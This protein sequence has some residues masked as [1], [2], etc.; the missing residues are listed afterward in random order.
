MRQWILVTL[1]LGAS[2]GA[3]AQ[4][5]GPANSSPL[6]GIDEIAVV[7][8]N[9]SIS[10]RQL[11]EEI[12]RERSLIPADIEL[13]PSVLEQQLTERVV[14]A[15]LIQQLK[16]RLN[17]SANDEEI[18]AAIA[19]VAQQNGVSPSELLK[20]VRR[21][22]GL[23]EQAYRAQIA[24]TIS[25]SK[26]KQGLVG[27][28]I[29]VTPT[30]IDAQIAQ[31]AR[32]SNVAIELQDLL[33]PRPSGNAEERGAAVQEQM[34]SLSQALK[35]AD[36]DLEQVAIAMPEARL[37]NLGT[38]SMAQI[39]PRF[40]QAIATQPIGEVLSEPVVD[41]DGMHFLK[42]LSRQSEGNVVIPEA[43]V[44]HILLR[45]EGEQDIAAQKVLIDELYQR[46]QQGADFSVLASQYSQD[47]ASAARG[48]KLGWMSA[49]Q[50][51]PA[52][53][54]AML[55][56]PLNTV[57]QPFLSPYGWHIVRV[58]DRREVD[59]ADDVLRARIRESLFNKYL[60]DAWQQ[61]LIQLRQQAY[62]EFR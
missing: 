48:G 28:D 55:N 22:T 52:F 23:D 15:H 8:N 16:Q 14:M 34:R 53:A 29:N 17:V 21:D 57:S 33:L 61:R 31:I 1:L 62:V 43:N 44:E 39:P 5:F 42:V 9:E 59:R 6:Q 30:D 2:I 10:R 12:A 56:V 51:V 4:Q 11:A 24:N 32:Q 46:L 37:V 54:N 7:I 60:E 19:N 41:S 3:S 18:S 47:P 38:V 25:E 36:G 27:R 45:A 50:V 35:N 40:A 49:D 58:S 20:R 13:P 26:L